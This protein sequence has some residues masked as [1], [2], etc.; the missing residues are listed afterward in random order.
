MKLKDT[1]TAWEPGTDRVKVGPLIYPGEPD[2]AYPYSMTGGAAYTHVRRFE[3]KDA[4]LFVM[5]EFIGVVVRDGCDPKAAHAAYLEIDEYR[6]SVP[7]DMVP[8]GYED[9]Q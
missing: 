2:W 5:S 4:R 1:L 7:V 3:G 9:D 6:Q 8:E